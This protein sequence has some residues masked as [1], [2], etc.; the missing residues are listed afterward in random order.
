MNLEIERLERELSDY[1][2][3]LNEFEIGK[4]IGHGGFSEVYFGIQKNSGIHCALKILNI[5]TLNGE[6]LIVYE[7]E[8]RILADSSN[9]FILGF[10]GF[11]T[12]YPFTI[13]SVFASK[14]S[15]YDALHHMPNAPILS[16]TQKTL[17]ALGIAIGMWRLHKIRVIH[18]DLKSLNILLDDECIPKICDFGLSRYVKTPETILTVDIGT[19]HW[20]APELF[21]GHDYTNKVDVYAYGMLLWEI[22]VGAYPF[23][24]KTA[25]Q[26]AYSVCKKKDRPKIPNRTPEGLKFLIQQC[27][28][29]NPEDRPTF[30]QIYKYFIAGEIR[31]PGTDESNLEVSLREIEKNRIDEKLNQKIDPNYIKK[32]YNHSSK[33]FKPMPIEFKTN[34]LPQFLRNEE[35]HHDINFDLLSDC[36]SAR[37]KEN[38][39]EIKKKILPEH[40]TK[41][42]SII[43][44]HFHPAVPTD[45]LHF[46]LTKTSELIW[47]HNNFYKSF[48]EKQIFIRIPFDNLHLADPLFEILVKVFEKSPEIVDNRVIESLPLYINL[49]PLQILRL[50]HIYT[51]VHF[52]LPNFWICTDILF[53]FSNLFLNSNFNSQY[54][55]LLFTLIQLHENFKTSRIDYINQVLLISLQNINHSIVKLTYEILYTLIDQNFIIDQSILITHLRDPIFWNYSVSILS[56]TNSISPNIDLLMSLLSL[57]QKSE[58]ANLL[59]C[60]LCE[61]ETSSIKIAE[62]VDDWAC[63]PLPSIEYTLRLVLTIL[64]NQR[65]RKYFQK[66]ESLME[67]FKFLCNSKDSRLINPISTVISCLKVTAEF[68]EL[69]TETEFLS[70]YFS[71]S[72]LI[73]ESSILLG[74]FTTAEILARVSWSDDF[75]NLFILLKIIIEQEQN[76]WEI[77]CVS[78]L[79]TL[80]CYEF[81]HQ[82]IISFGFIEFIES[83]K[84]RDDIS[85]YILVFLKNMKLN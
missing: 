4:Q 58:L 39:D 76:G 35:I 42:F 64:N 57:S 85:Q 38:F 31:F 32:N 46:L 23:K 37:F 3:T 29:Q 5:K 10:V 49:K 77:H 50:I 12:T 69:A 36:F 22:L 67:L 24:G 70:H 2:V 82:D 48:L 25:V 7:R 51:C 41:L 78:L 14:G 43:L 16:G 73:K 66:S 62:I 60:R 83:L 79:A 81:A 21:E 44:P 19:P 61:N 54:L 68:V 18:R 34:I 30:H 6:K 52:Q 45:I 26:I 74:C 1:V 17:I 11:T 72:M 59:L 8:I 65:T 80:S 75:L 53:T 9:K 71:I 55:R 15:L 20:M 84:Y 28:A 47:D 27:W 40:S 56:K 33:S 13:I 63:L